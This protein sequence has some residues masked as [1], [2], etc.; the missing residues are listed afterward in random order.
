[1][2]RIS[3][4]THKLAKQLLVYLWRDGASDNLLCQLD[5]NYKAMLVF[6]YLCR[7]AVFNVE[8]WA[9]FRFIILPRHH[10]YD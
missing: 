9:L 5:V 6:V 1:M 3:G 8:V 4:S 7:Q 10:Q 2:R